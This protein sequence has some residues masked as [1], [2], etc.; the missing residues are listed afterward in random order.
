[1]D[2]I[3]EGSAFHPDNLE[4]V[5]LIMMMRLYDLQLALLSVYDAEKATALAA[6]HEEGH[7]LCPAPAFIGEEDG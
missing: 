3:N 5:K 6:M 1:M 2:I 4:Q 7:I